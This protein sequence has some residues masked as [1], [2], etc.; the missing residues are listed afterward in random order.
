MKRIASDEL[1]CCRLAVDQLTISP[2]SN[3]PANKH[4]VNIQD[5][6]HN[7]IYGYE[8]HI[9]GQGEHVL[10]DR[11][12]HVANHKEDFILWQTFKQVI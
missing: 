7:C 12:V 11:P 4:I 2:P 6:Y 8:E 1:R 9:I 5:L 10:T 3:R